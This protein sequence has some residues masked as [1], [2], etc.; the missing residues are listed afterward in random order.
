MDWGGKDFQDIMAGVD[1][2]IE[3]GVADPDHMAIMGGSYGGF[4][5]FWAVTQTNRFKAAIGHAAISD[6]YSFY[7]QTDIPYLLEFGFGGVPWV[8]K[9]VFERWSPIEHAENVVT[10]LLITHGEEDR[11][12]PIPQGEQYYRT[13]KK[14][15][16]TVEFIRFPREGHG[17]RE[18]R[19]R[20][21]LDKEQ[22]KWIERYLFPEGR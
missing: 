15:G 17:I 6:W 10:P 4:M 2:V 3:M 5:T 14:M 8:T 19:H 12:V 20:L 9:D 11:R 1:H 22:E 7:G 18:P 21:F 16:K 13:L